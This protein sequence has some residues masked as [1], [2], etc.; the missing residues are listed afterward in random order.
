MHA[1]NAEL[2]A[3]AECKHYH[4][5]DD[6]YHIC[7]RPVMSII[8]GEISTNTHF[9]NTERY[10]ADRRGVQGKFSERKTGEHDE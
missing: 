2:P 1:E 4:I 9:C 6:E 8:T 5:K 10:T 3:C 7:N